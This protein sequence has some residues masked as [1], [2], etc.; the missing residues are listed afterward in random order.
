MT[1]SSQGSLHLRGRSI[2]LS[3]IVGCVL[4][5]ASAGSAPAAEPDKGGDRAVCAEAY[6][7]AQ[8]QRRSGSLRRARESLLLCVSDRCPAVIQPDCL[9]WLTE[10]EAAM[11][12]VTFA[13]KGVDGKDVTDVRVSLDGQPLRSSL[14]GKAIAID[15]GSHTLRFEHGAEVPVDQS[16]VVREGEKARVISVSWSKAAA[17]ESGADRGGVHARTGPPASV[18]VFGGIGVASLATFGAL[19]FHGM[20]RRSDLETECFGSCDQA[21]ID[22]IK[23]ELAVADVALGIGVV[24]LGISTVIFLTSGSSEKPSTAA[25]AIPTAR[26]VSVGVAPQRNG[27]ALGLSGRF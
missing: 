25:K 16:L 7:N 12:T 26:A 27:A 15:P 1:S 10:V 24:S 11:P 19:A 5:A 13:A 18:W 8:T 20:Q 17:S 2:A 22:S 6:R 21:R 4:V 14:D 9:R 3:A 23:S